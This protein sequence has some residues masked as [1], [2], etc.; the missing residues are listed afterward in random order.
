MRRKGGGV[1]RAVFVSR[2]FAGLSTLVLVIVAARVAQLK[3]DP[4][5]RLSVYI[6]NRVGFERE[7]SARGDLLDRRGRPVSMSEVGFRVVIDPVAAESS[8][9]RIIVAL[10]DTLGVS[11]EE[12]GAPLVRAVERNRE[13]RGMSAAEEAVRSADAGDEEEDRSL[14]DKGETFFERVAG[15]I[16]GRGARSSA[17]SSARRPSLRRYVPVGPV[18]ERGVAGVVADLRLPGV[19]VEKVQVRHYPGG[20]EIASI[21]GKVGFGHVGLLGA[22]R[23]LDARLRGEDGRLG[24]VHDAVS[25]PVLIEPVSSSAGTRG[26]DVRLSIDLELQ[27]IAIEEL[28]RGMEDADAAGGRLVMMDPRTGE[29]LAMVDR[30]REV[31]GLV[32]FP[33]VEPGTPREAWPSLPPEDRRPRYAT[34]PPDPGRGVHPALGR[35]RCVEDIYEPGSTFKSFVWASAW[36]AGVIGP[37]ETIDT[38]PYVTPFGRRFQDV[39]RRSSQTWEDVLVHSSNVGM[40]RLSE[41]MSHQALRDSILRFGFGEPTRLGLPGEASGIVTAKEDWT[42]FTHT[43]V[44]IGHEVAV[45]PVQ[46]VRAFGAYARTGELAGTLPQLRLTSPSRAELDAEPVVRVLDPGVASRTRA[47]LERVAERMDASTRRR[48]ADEP[49]PGYSMFGKSGTAD[50]PVVAPVVER[51]GKRVRLGVPRGGRGYFNNQYN[52][53]FIAGAPTNEPVIVVLVVIDDPGP[54]RV[55][56]KQHYGSSVAGPVVRRVVERSL[57]YLGVPP[58]EAVA[59]G[60]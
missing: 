13:I 49:R 17:Q 56:Q 16:T 60:G 31:P 41:R 3:I 25:R 6:S 44:V 21:V 27:R 14:L 11:T 9:D 46:M 28:E 32:P 26:E 57:R 33:W 48:F 1:D 55:R 22:E 58:V 39:T 54:A 5:E 7:P 18:L 10:A 15:T 35:N 34:L 42:A 37:G 53:S 45:T 47:V 38:H 20:D 24:Y 12:V 19:T 4:G 43:S 30:Y 52:S 50:I 23:S 51:D 59:S 40:V 29:I 2:F 8:M 36:Q